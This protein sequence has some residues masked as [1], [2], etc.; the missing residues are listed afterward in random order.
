MHQSEGTPQPTLVHTLQKSLSSLIFH[1]QPSL[2]HSRIYLCIANA[3]QKCSHRGK[4]QKRVNLHLF[5]LQIFTMGL[6]RQE[7]PVQKQNR[8][9]LP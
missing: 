1:F 2:I 4:F 6:L 8:Q 5:S 9:S 7:V 3:Q